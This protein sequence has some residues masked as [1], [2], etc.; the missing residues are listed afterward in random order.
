MFDVN[1]FLTGEPA[2]ERLAEAYVPT[3]AQEAD[4]VDLTAAIRQIQDDCTATQ[5]DLI[6]FLEG[7]RTEADFIDDEVSIPQV[8]ATDSFWI[9]NAIAADLSYAT[10]Q[11]VLD[12]SDVAYV[13]LSRNVDLEELLD[14][15]TSVC[16][17]NEPQ[18]AT[19]PRQ[20]GSQYYNNDG[21][22]GQSVAPILQ[23]RSAP[24][25]SVIAR[26]R[27]ARHKEVSNW[28]GG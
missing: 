13:E 23:D 8:G 11:R 27:S 14:A 16:P 24:A 25:Q 6:G 10:L 18:T 4:N 1:I 17:T 28:V 7:C 21:L 2:A 26:R 12:R 15:E 19:R 9:N 20:W 3:D 5:Q 22:V